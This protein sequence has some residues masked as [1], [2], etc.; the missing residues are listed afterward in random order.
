MLAILLAV[1]INSLSNP[2]R[3]S[4]GPILSEEDLFN[5]FNTL[6]LKVDKSIRE[7]NKYDLCSNSKK[8]KVFIEAFQQRLQDKEP[9]YGWED[10]KE[11]ISS[12]SEKA[13]KRNI[14]FQ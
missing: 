12:L 10:I 2:I 9:N 11:L 5:N 8:T 1:I 7:N 14:L 3:C 6:L 13:C 4:H